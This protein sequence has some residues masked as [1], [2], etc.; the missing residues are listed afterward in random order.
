[1]SKEQVKAAAAAAQS[2]KPAKSPVAETDKVPAAK[3]QPKKVLKRRQSGDFWIN[4]SV[5]LFIGV[6]LLIL[7]FEI[8]LKLSR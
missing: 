8:L 1:M 7:S 6:C 4:L 3:A 5:A 2:T